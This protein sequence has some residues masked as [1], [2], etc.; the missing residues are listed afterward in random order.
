MK[1]SFLRSFKVG[2]LILLLWVGSV[3]CK[4]DRNN[5]EREDFQIVLADSINIDFL[6]NLKLKDYDPNLDKYLLSNEGMDPLLEV[7]YNGNIIYVYSISSEGPNAI[8]N[9]GTAGYVDGNLFIYDMEKG[10]FKSNYDDTFSNEFKIPYQHTYLIFPPHLPLIKKTSEDLYY[11]KPLTDKDFTD[12]M[13]EKFYANLYEKPLME[14]LNIRTGEL[15]SYLPIPDNS[16][17]K[18]GENHGIYIPIIKNKG[19]EWLVS[20]WFDPSIYLYEE[21]GDSISFVKAVDLKI[22]GM[23]NYTSIPMSNS[24]KFYDINSNIKAGNIN[25]ILFLNDY[26]IVIYRKGLTES[27]QQKIKSNYPE[28]SNVE[29]ERKDPFYAVILDKNYN[30]LQSDVMFPSGVYYPNIINKNNEIVA[31]KN[32]DLFDVEGSVITLYKLE[33]K[34]Q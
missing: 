33:L 8:P 1:N 14:R 27:D 12:G 5:M 20:T 13:G 2:T 32:A 7:D 34:I 28:N 16:L 15:K 3:A 22:Q 24:E 6:G 17:F 21:I 23:V 29:L 25:D 4:S 19:H 26:T 30:V 31:L 11:F 9:P 10:L 18:D